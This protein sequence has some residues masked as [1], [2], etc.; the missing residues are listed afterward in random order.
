MQDHN[1]KILINFRKAQSHITKIIVMLEKKEYCINTIQQ[2]LAVIGLLKSANQMLMKNHL[3]FCFQ[4]AMKSSNKKRKQEMI[5]EI[6]KVIKF[7]NK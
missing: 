1:Q 5:S 4:K 3:S 2:S 6:L 7:S